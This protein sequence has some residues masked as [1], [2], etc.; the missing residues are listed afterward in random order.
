MTDHTADASN[1]V[2]PCACALCGSQ[3]RIVYSL[4][5]TVLPLCDCR[6][7]IDGDEMDIVSWNEFN[8]RILAMRKKDFE[9]GR[10]IEQGCGLVFTDFEHY[11]RH[12]TEL[13][14]H[15]K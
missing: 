4:T 2:E 7:V 6:P 13:E 3:E 8:R 11:M 12:A 10:W 5:D 15:G 14:K 1:K 9:A